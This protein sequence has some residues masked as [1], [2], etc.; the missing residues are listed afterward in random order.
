[1][2]AK[3]IINEDEIDDMVYGD[4][5]LSKITKF[6]KSRNPVECILKTTTVL[7]RTDNVNYFLPAEY[8]GKEI[9]IYVEKIIEDIDENIAKDNPELIPDMYDEDAFRFDM[10][11]K[12]NAERWDR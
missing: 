3:Y 6:K 11:R 7:I 9:K 12:E 5:D 2:R 10:E 1:M 4:M 8:Q